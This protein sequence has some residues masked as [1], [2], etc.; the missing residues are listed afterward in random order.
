[1]WSV[2]RSSDCWLRTT[3]QGLR[4]TNGRI[5]NSETNEV[6]QAA[7]GTDVRGSYEGRGDFFWRVRI[8]S[9]GASLDNRQADRSFSR[10]YDSLREA[11]RENLD[12]SLPRQAHHEETGGNSYGQRQGSA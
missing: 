2:V 6:P 12:S 11:R 10:C 5:Q 7:A 8:E 3:D 1:P 4:T 9:A